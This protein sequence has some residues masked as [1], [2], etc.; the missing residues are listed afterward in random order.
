MVS[1]WFHGSSWRVH[2]V[3]P[4]QILKVTAALSDYYY[5]T[6]LFSN[7]LQTK[8]SDIVDP[9]LEVKVKFVR[10]MEGPFVVLAQIRLL[11]T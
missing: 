5:L 2:K 11:Q 8:W 10:F 9:S 7:Y 1:N 3:Y 6:H 4:L